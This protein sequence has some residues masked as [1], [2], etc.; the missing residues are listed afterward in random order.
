MGAME[1]APVTEIHVKSHWLAMTVTIHVVRF[2]TYS[3]KDELTLPWSRPVQRILRV[4]RRCGN[5]SLLHCSIV[6]DDFR[7]WDE[8]NVVAS[9]HSDWSKS[10]RGLYGREKCIHAVTTTVLIDQTPCSLPARARIV[11]RSMVEQSSAYSW[12]IPEDAPLSEAMQ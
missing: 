9:S 1:S 2:I 8:L 7:A 3:S 12:L 10:W 11:P 5:E 4:R 6:I